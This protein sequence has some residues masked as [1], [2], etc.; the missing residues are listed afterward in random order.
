ME[1]KK[2]RSLKKIWKFIPLWLLGPFSSFIFCV[3]VFINSKFIASYFINVVEYM[4]EIKSTAVSLQWILQCDTDM[5]NENETQCFNNRRIKMKHCVFIFLQATAVG[6]WRLRIIPRISSRAH[7]I[8][9]SYSVG[10]FSKSVVL[11]FL[12]FFLIKKVKCSALFIHTI[13]F[14]IIK[15]FTRKPPSKNL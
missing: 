15:K 1:V 12:P 2:W 11:F 7:A 13:H 5:Q 6:I 9:W 8:W 10:R 4:A 14:C 3:D